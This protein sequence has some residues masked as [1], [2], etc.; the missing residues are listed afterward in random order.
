MAGKLSVTNL[1]VD[2]ALS[3]STLRAVNHASF[4][5]PSGHRI[6][7]VGESGSGKS[8]LGLAMMGLLPPNASISVD[9][10][11]LD[12]QVLN[13]ANPRSLQTIRGRKM[14]MVFQDAKASLDPVRTIRSQITEVL[15][16]HKIV[17][18]EKYE[19]EVIRLLSQ[20]EIPHPE[21]V[22]RQY[23]HELSGGMRQRAMIAVALAGTPSILIADEPTSALDVTT[24]ATVIDLLKRLSENGGM[25]TLLVT[26]DLAL[27][28][29]FAQS[30]MVMYAGNLVEIGSVEE[31]YAKPSHPYTKALLAAIPNISADR[32]SELGT[33]DGLLPD[34][35]IKNL[36][37]IFEPRCQISNG[38]KLCRDESPKLRTLN[39]T[40]HVACHF[41]DDVNSSQRVNLVSKQS[42]MTDVMDLNNSVLRRDSSKVLTNIVEVTEVC[43]TF[44]GGSLF[45][46]NRS[47]VDA[48]KDATLII[49]EGESVGL[50]GESGSGK[51]TL[52]RIIVG[53]ETKNSGVVIICGTNRDQSNR[54]SLNGEIQFVFQDPGDSLN[55]TL[56]VE[57]IISE[58]LVLRN[59]GKSSDFHEN[60][61]RLL[62]D[63]G[64]RES[65]AF[66]RSSE[67]SGGQRQR[68]AIARAISTD[69]KLI[70]AD[71]A[72]AS[73]DMSAR[74]QILNLLAKLQRTKG[75]SYLY[76]SHD[77]STVRHVCD[78]V[79]VM[80]RGCVVEEA[81][82]DEIF[83]S[84]E[85]PYTQALISAVP[86]PDPFIER[87]RI[88]ISKVKNES[89]DENRG[90]SCAYLNSCGLARE[91]C[92]I[93][94]PRIVLVN[95]HGTA[96]HFPTESAQRFKKDSF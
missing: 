16:V 44:K 75:F 84:P 42:Q 29:S 68:V 87:T 40:A 15:K 57:Q 13:I 11:K 37:C 79:V 90:I 35:T 74:G 21:V 26:H 47:Q 32:V 80:Y 81:S 49:R 17:T 76:I 38:R 46:A 70:I 41:S 54:K 51:T 71:E 78:R 58:P 69:P 61:A 89:F 3:S 94:A 7:V 48:V 91:Q 77:L 5:I 93:E 59:G 96:C 20:V 9:E 23:P 85:H 53:L 34:L 30:V 1:S 60:V 4:E 95:G 39:A 67:L 82:A 72:V 19:D 27:V 52:A 50:V 92:S 14:A 33:I 6:A 28:A 2:Y 56:S 24:Q 83:T 63:V 55:P 12:D 43:K 36:G 65:M 8:T 31:I 64:L 22:A 88:R 25:T 86:I 73:L 45:S 62:V 66:R 10:L 18:A